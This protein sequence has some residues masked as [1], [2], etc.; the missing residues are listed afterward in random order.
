[1][2]R[3]HDEVLLIDE[4]ISAIAELKDLSRFGDLGDLGRVV[5]ALQALRRALEVDLTTLPDLPV[6]VVTVPRGRTLPWKV[7]AVAAG[8]VLALTT[9]GL[10][11]A[12]TGNP[13]APIYFIVDKVANL[14]HQDAHDQPWGAPKAEQPVDDASQSTQSAKPR[15]SHHHAPKSRQK[16]AADAST[17]GG[18]V[19]QVS[20]S[21]SDPIVVNPPQTVPEADSAPTVPE[22]TT[23]PVVRDVVKAPVAKVV[24][25][26]S[27]VPDAVEPL[28]TAVDGV[29]SSTL[30]SPLLGL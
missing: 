9:S 29:L 22:E 17:D 2:A 19:D 25:A 27:A 15:A 1:M 8:G 28:V 3:S 6:L 13:L 16:P 5:D 26:V 14:T 18:A 21:P 7:S 24:T 11:A 20:D 23:P 10:A 12:V 4:V 30:D